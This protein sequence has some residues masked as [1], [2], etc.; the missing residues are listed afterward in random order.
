[1]KAN[2][3]DDE[4]AA[5]SAERLA[6]FVV[7]QT[8]SLGG[9]GGSAEAFSRRL[10]EFRR[11]RRRR[12]WVVPAL[13]VS[14]LL[15]VFGLAGSRSP[16]G[17]R[18]TELSYRVNDREPQ[19]GGYLSS[20]SGES[21]VTFSDGSRVSML[22]KARGRVVELGPQRARIALESGRA[23]VHIVPRQRTHWTFD[24]GPFVV[25]VHGTA[26]DVAWD[27]GEAIFELRLISGSV[28]IASPIGAPEIRLRE[29]QTLRVNLRDQT[30][31][32]GS[33]PV[34]IVSAQTTQRADAPARQSADL[35]PA[36]RSAWSHRRWNEMVADGKALA[37]LADAERS[38][39]E[40]VFDGADSDD[41]WALADAARYKGRLAIAKQA[42][43]AQRTRFPSSSRARE[44]AFLLGRLHDRDSEGPSAA[45]GWY[46]RYL[47][48]AP[49]G[50]HAADALG[51]KIT[52]LERW[53]RR[54]EAV[55]V[56]EEY[57]RRFP[58]GTYGRAA[59]ALL[60]A[61]TVQR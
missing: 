24:V 32:I 1:M 27:P 31:T 54:D 22:P 56:A 47:V 48:E 18:R 17:E 9:A 59:R 35:A 4:P 13:A 52:L 45:L 51:R 58:S 50:A 36:P 5:G 20:D 61:S 19:A 53:N 34:G 16:E 6:D 60:Q 25:T 3:V 55:A 26:F 49:N 10:A 39:L 8:E 15:V 23:S 2:A 30:S 14:L 37:V 11:S 12:Q 29:G 42:L 43:T 40:I 21:R 57:L 33:G 7:R 44:A 28:S 41:L 46:D 38:G